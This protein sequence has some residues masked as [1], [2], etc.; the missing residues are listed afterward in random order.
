MSIRKVLLRD[1]GS[2]DSGGV[3]NFPNLHTLDIRGASAP[4]VLEEMTDIPTVLYERSLRHRSTASASAEDSIVNARPSPINTLYMSS[5]PFYSITRNLKAEGR[6]YVG[7]DDLLR[8]QRLLVCLALERIVP[9]FI[10]E[11][12]SRY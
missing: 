11:E 4:S 5:P 8:C 2:V 12:E 1:A 9:N 6:K 7:K 10:W 3:W